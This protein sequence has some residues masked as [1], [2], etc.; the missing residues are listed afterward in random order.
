MWFSCHCLAFWPNEENCSCHLDNHHHLDIVSVHRIVVTTSLN[1]LQ[2]GIQPQAASVLDVPAGSV[3]SNLAF[4]CCDPSGQPVHNGME[5]I[6]ELSWV[7]GPKKA[8]LDHGLLCLP[9]LQVQC[10]LS[11]AVASTHHSI[12]ADSFN[13][14]HI[15]CLC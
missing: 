10:S 8:S 11:D 7:E 13:L 6:V 12:C 15:P 3:L 2:D 5:G 1:G 4:Y 14:H 9:D